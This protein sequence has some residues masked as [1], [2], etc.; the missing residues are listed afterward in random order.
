[1]GSRAA[2]NGNAS[3][4]GRSLRPRRAARDFYRKISFA[5][6]N[7]LRR[8][9]AQPEPRSAARKSVPHPG[10][11][12]AT[13]KFQDARAETRLRWRRERAVANPTL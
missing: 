1:V 11:Q 6:N 7:D 12:F 3:G 4:R 13:A 9:P 5:A 2:G 8:S 10:L